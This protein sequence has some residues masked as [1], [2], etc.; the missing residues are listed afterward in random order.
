MTRNKTEKTRECKV[1]EQREVDFCLM[2][3]TNQLKPCVQ[4]LALLL[5]NVYSAWNALVFDIFLPQ[6]TKKNMSRGNTSN[7]GFV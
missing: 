5:L 1:N 4:G 3:D 7:T 6:I 2:G